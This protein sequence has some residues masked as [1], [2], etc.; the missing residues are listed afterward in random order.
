MD[1]AVAGVAEEKI[2]Y[3]S[4]DQ[5]LSLVSD[6]EAAMAGLEGMVWRKDSGG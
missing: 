6:S 4:G 3:W 1:G 2:P 5:S